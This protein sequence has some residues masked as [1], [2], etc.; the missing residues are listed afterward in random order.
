[1][2]RFLSP[3]IGLLLAG[4]LLSA[5]CNKIPEKKQETPVVQDMNI[6]RP[7]AE[8]SESE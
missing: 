6:V 5:G 7:D 3:L 4:L 8:E 1:M 2:V